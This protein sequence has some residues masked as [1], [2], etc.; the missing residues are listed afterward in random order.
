MKRTGILLFC[1]FLHQ[2]AIS[3]TPPI[4]DQYVVNP[5]LINPAATGLRG[6]IS[7]AALYRKQWVGIKGAP[8]TLMFLAEAPFSGSKTG[9]GLQVISDKYGVTRENSIAST[10]SYRIDIN[11]GSISLGLKAGILTSNTTWS[12]L[13]ALDPG[14]DLLLIDSK[15]FLVPDFAFGAYYSSEKNYAG[16]SIP[17][18]LQY[19]FNSEKNKYSIKIN[20][21]RY[22]LLFQAGHVFEPAPNLKFQPS[23]LLLFTS[24]KRAL[25]DVNMHL[26]FE[27]KVWAGVSYRSNNSLAGLFQFALSNQLKAAYSY[28]YDFGKI[29]RFS[30]G[31]HE[32]MLRFDLLF[33]ADVVNPLI[34]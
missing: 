27:E 19:E 34:F 31:S 10:Y 21:L 26:I 1:I 16:F 2:F 3:Q 23:L 4:V 24:G 18:L 12:E 15:T 5:V 32:I 8:E 20:P 11:E 6:A 13:T 9:V 25:F 7:F 28:Y 14:D 30:Q 29:G 22:D 17:R 33:K